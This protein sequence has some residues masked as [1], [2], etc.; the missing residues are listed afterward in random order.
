M[1]RAPRR[2]A[3]LALALAVAGC[4]PRY[5]PTMTSI[6]MKGGPPDATVLVDDQPI[7]SLG[8]VI[9]RGMAVLPGRHRITVER[10]GYFPW[11]RAIDARGELIALEV[12]LIK[13]PE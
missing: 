12:T 6:R 9:R 11:D 4:Q 7:A 2:A 1:I 3:L 5:G 8:Q 13:I 10:D